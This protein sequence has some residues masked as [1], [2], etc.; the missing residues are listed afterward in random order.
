MS[1]HKR[2]RKDKK[3]LTPPAVSSNIAP[4]HSSTTW[5]STNIMPKASSL[6][7]DEINEKA[8]LEEARETE[9]KAMRIAAFKALPAFLRQHVANAILWRQA[10]NSIQAMCAPTS[11]RLRALESRDSSF[12]TYFAY[13]GSYGSY[14]TREHEN[15]GLSDDEL[16]AAH[17][18][19]AAEE[20][21][22]ATPA[23]SMKPQ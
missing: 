10:V 5:S 14:S 20:A 12:A 2:K 17:T 13:D 9:T 4:M 16:L 1:R 6:S 15:C 3:V 19:A 8:T 7:P 21:L 11:A 18:E 22:L 23:E